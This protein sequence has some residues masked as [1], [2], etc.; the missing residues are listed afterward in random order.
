M[1][2]AR[3]GVEQA[4]EGATACDQLG[5]DGLD[6]VVDDLRDGL[7]GQPRQRRVRA[8]AAGVGSGVAVAD[9]L[10]V[11]GGQQRHDGLAVDEAEQ[12]NL[13]TVEEGFEEN[14]VPGLEQFGRMIARGVADRW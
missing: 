12:R 7:V 10:V 2:I 6:D 1:P 8:H 3:P 11:L 4:G 5:R 9:A 13:G 14:R